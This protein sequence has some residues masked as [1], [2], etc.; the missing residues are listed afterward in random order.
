MEGRNGENL[1]LLA[2]GTSRLNDEVIRLHGHGHGIL[3]VDSKLKLL[4]FIA[5]SRF[6][7]EAAFSRFNRLREEA[8]TTLTS[9]F[10]RFIED[11]D[12]SQPIFG[13]NRPGFPRHS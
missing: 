8:L 11:R 6:C 7:R 13:L 1:F 4:F 12:P 9:T 3:S 2:Y 5:S 10:W